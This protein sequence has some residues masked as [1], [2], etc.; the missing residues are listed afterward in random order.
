MS[1]R[2]AK[3]HDIG[4]DCKCYQLLAAN[5][6]IHGREAVFSPFCRK[7]PKRLAIPFVD[8]HNTTRSP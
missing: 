2:Q 3:G 4:T 5:R 6:D 8:Y 7:M 1:L